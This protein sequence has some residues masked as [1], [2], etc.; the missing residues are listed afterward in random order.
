[1]IEKILAES[2]FKKHSK[3][4]ALAFLKAGIRTKE[5]LESG[6][7]HVLIRETFGYDLEE[8]VKYLIENWDKPQKKEH[9][10][11][12]VKEAVNVD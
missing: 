7:A 8:V 1:M 6:S 5:S 10:K 2:K 12:V 11:K 3:K 4:L 9:K